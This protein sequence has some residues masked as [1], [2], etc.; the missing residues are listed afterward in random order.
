VTDWTN[1]GLGLGP[2]GCNAGDFSGVDV[3]I[4]CETPVVETSPFEKLLNKLF[5]RINTASGPYQMVNVLTDG[6]VFQCEQDGKVRAE[7]MEDVPLE[8]FNARFDALPRIHWNFGYTTQRQALWDSRRK[9]TS[10]EV[11]L[12]YYPGVTCGADVA[13]VPVMTRDLSTSRKKE[14]L[15]LTEDLYGA[16]PS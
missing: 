4:D 2:N 16:L 12:T 10:F 8:Y 1:G 3:R 9:G 15:K 11:H 13:G 14:K 7:Y 6:V 5:S